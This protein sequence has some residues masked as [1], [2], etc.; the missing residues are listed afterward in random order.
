MNVRQIL[1]PLRS[2]QRMPRS[3]SEDAL[4]KKRILKEGALKDNKKYDHISRLKA[5]DETYSGRYL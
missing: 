5:R 2:K 3:E 1:I 4:N